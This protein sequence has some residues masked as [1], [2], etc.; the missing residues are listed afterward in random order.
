[1]SWDVMLT[2]SDAFAGECGGSEQSAA[3]FDLPEVIS[4]L[5]Q[6][7]AGIDCADDSWLHYEGDIFAISFN[8]SNR[9]EIMLHIHILDEPE[10]AVLAVISELC[11]LLGCRA[12]DTTT[13][14][15]LQF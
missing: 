10:D 7:F 6:K 13:G 4:L 12:F 15:Y 9:Q 14:E 11:S 2:K 5:K 8:L 1:M 3:L